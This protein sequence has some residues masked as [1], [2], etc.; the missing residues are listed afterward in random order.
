MVSPAA[1]ALLVAATSYTPREGAELIGTPA[2]PWQ[3]L[4][5]LNRGPL[6]L[7]DLRGKIVLLRFW[8]IDC[9]YCTRTLPVLRDLEREYGPRGLVVVGIHHPKSDAAR[10]PEAV[11]AA[12][13]ALAIDFPIAL[14]NDWRTVSAYGVGRV[15]QR[16]TSVSFLIDR[17]GRIRF[18]HDGGEYHPGGGAKHR[19]CNAAY[20]A[21]RQAIE[22][23]LAE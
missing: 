19:D 11:A 20:A 10:S 6:S 5:W 4:R 2:P 23:A 17:Q 8:L 12:A 9:P 15:F 14:D 3:G 21:L 18:V 22:R 13:R 1:L 16:F 7:A